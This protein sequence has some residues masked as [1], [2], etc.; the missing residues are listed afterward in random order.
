MKILFW[1]IRGLG[2]AGRRKQLSDLM[3]DC[4][5]DIMCLQ[6]TIKLD[7]TQTELRNLGEG[8]NFS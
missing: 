8:G 5:V 6:E 3:K 2:G 7:F 1:N 4:K